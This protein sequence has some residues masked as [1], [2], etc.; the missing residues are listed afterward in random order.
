MSDTEE[1]VRVDVWLWRAR[2]FKTRA[3]A[4]RAVGEGAARL[5]RG[6]ESRTLDK[7]SAY[8]RTGDG[9]T[10]RVGAQFRSVRILSLGLRRGPAKEARLLYASAEGDL[11]GGRPDRQTVTKS[12]GEPP[13]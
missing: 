10:V 2:F 1:Q 12:G 5:A 8:V 9:L 7:P 11:D 13:L 6:T 3:L 4:A